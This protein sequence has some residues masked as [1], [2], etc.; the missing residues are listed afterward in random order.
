MVARVGWR[1]FH[2]SGLVARFVRNMPVGQMIAMIR[3]KGLFTYRIW[4]F[5]RWRLIDM[6]GGVRQKLAEFRQQIAL[7]FKQFGHLTVHFLFGQMFDV[8]T[9][10]RLFHCALLLLVRVQNLQETFVLLWLALET[11]LKNQ[12]IKYKKVTQRLSMSVMT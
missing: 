2:R 7:I 10:V 4:M 5:R 3:F 9:D 11:I 8:W 12:N 1:S 6:T